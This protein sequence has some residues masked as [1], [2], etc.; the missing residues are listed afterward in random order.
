MWP[1]PVINFRPSGAEKERT[2][3]AGT[4]PA[5]HETALEMSRKCK[6]QYLW[7]ILSMTQRSPLA[8]SPSISIWSSMWL[9]S[10]M[11]TPYIGIWRPVL[12]T[13]LTYIMLILLLLRHQGFFFSL[14]QILGFQCGGCSYCGL[15]ACVSLVDGYRRFDETICYFPF[16]NWS[17]CIHSSM[18]LQPFV[19]PWPFLQ[20][21][22]LFYTDGRTPWASDQPVA[23]PLPTR[24]TTQTQNKRTRRHTCLEWNSNPWSQHSSERRHFMPWT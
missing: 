18:A 4:F 22:N 17:D 1:L 9:V 20:F 13:L 14:L 7:L 16:R 19:G 21:R 8:Y 5:V 24:R 2:Y 12:L 15:L 10:H 23:R 6:L 11:K 3:I